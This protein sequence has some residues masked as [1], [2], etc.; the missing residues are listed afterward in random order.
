MI[1]TRPRLRFPSPALILSCVALFAAL[2]GGAYAAASS[3]TPTVRWTTATLMNGWQTHLGATASVGYAKDSAGVVHLR[4]TMDN[5]VD[6]TTAF[7]L[8]KRMRPRHTTVL[9]L[10]TTTPGAEL[11]INSDGTVLPIGGGDTTYTSFDG[12]SFVA[13]Q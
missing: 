4:G 5:G 2:G 12:I 3:G 1:T 8:P 6:D 13:G 7:V 10:F 9:A 11:E